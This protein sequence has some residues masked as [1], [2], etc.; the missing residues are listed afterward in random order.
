[1]SSNALSRRSALRLGLAALGGTAL[2]GCS[3]PPP[4]GSTPS[5]SPSAS[6]STA[7]SPPNYGTAPLTGLPASAAGIATRP[8]VVV[9]L[10]LDGSAPAATGLAAADVVFEEVTGRGA[11]RLMAVYQSTDA[12]R[13][14]P[15]A[16]TW[17]SD[18]RTLPVLRPLVASRGGPQKF[19]NVL[20]STD[21]LTDVSYPGRSSAYTTQPGAPSPY[22]VYTST[23]AL[24]RLAPAGAAA[25]PG[26]LPFQE[27]GLPL[28]TTGTVAA[29]QVSVTVPGEPARV[30]SYDAGTR[31]WHRAGSAIACANLA[32]L[33]MP[34]RSVATSNHGGSI[35][36]AEVFG[37]G[38]AWVAAG[39]FAVHGSWSRK[40][41]FGA[42]LV[43]DASGFPARVV[44][45]T[46]WMLYA[47]TGST[48]VIA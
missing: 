21:G 19:T 11:R 42:S 35:R 17:P 24:Y 46:T 4:S 22:N 28:A 8:A 10:Y 47:P 45:G 14:G 9:D 33:V 7:P 23:A 39:A 36:T 31:Q 25:P 12:P 2:A 41:A 38:A 29:R 20:G 26:V 30:W 32:V 5:G 16:D 15:V 44:P 1:M 48:V 18:I 40:G 6:P 3:P 27:G 34:Y 13:I 37:S 43:L